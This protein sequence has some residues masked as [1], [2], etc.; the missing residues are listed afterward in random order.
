MPAWSSSG[1]EL[2]FVTAPDTGRGLFHADGQMMAVDV[3]SG[4]T[5][6]LGRPHPLFTYSP[7]V[8]GL[9]GWPVRPYAVAPDGQLFY[10]MRLV[11]RSP[12]APVTQIRLVTN[13]LDELKTRV[14]AGQ[15]KQ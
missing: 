6:E 11:P 4:P 10:A 14:A 12:R 15:A 8:D 13:W 9:G 1:R 2:F 5:L 3:R 7:E